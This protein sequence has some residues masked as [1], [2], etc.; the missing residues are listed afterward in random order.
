MPDRLAYRDAVSAAMREKELDDTHDRS[1]MT[2]YTLKFDLSVIPGENNRWPGCAAVTFAPGSDETELTK[3]YQ[4]WV[5]TMR[6][7]FDQEVISI[8]RRYL[9]DFL[10]DEEERKLV[11]FSWS[12]EERI[13]SELRKELKL[14]TEKTVMDFQFQVDRLGNQNPTVNALSRKMR[15]EE[16][17]VGKECR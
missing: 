1:G 3:Q 6:Q 5:A 12:E 17:R 10:T 16:R 9:R 8:Q 7:T 2:L 14:D 4:E 13:Q 11:I 15:S